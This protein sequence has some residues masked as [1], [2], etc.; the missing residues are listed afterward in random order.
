LAAPVWQAS[1]FGGIA[2]EGIQM[3][4]KN[5][6]ALGEETYRAVMRVEPPVVGSVLSAKML[7]LE[8]A[9]LWNRSVLNRTERRWITIA[10]LAC[11][12]DEVGV[13]AHV[14]GA[15]ASGD[16]SLEALQEGIFHCALYRGFPR[17]W[18]V[19]RA[20][21]DV[22]AEL[23]L[24]PDDSLDLD[25]I[26]W[27]SEDARLDVGETKYLSVMASR[28][29]RGAGPYQHNGVLQTV[30]AELWP[31]GVLTQRERRLITLACVGLSVAP[32]PVKMHCRVAMET[33][34][35][36]FEEMG[37]FI[38]HFAFYA[39]WPCASQMSISTSEAIQQLRQDTRND[40]LRRDIEAAHR[41]VGPDYS[42]DGYREA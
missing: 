36:S 39:G 3:D 20:M 40:Q 38:L 29:T 25:A 28:A 18:F 10:S 16:I 41:A 6:R 30:F 27:P 21:L 12:S 14:Y 33:G 31:R 9:E 32:L 26:G 5:R 2:A 37:E 42:V 7:D 17:A 22:A 8:F 35:L 34:D 11:L 23:G 4:S 1:S 13:R 19:E 24:S 15:L